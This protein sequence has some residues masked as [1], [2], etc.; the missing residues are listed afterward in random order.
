[1]DRGINNLLRNGF[2]VLLLLLVLELA[3]LKY[4]R[5]AAVPSQPILL[6]NFQFPALILNPLS[7]PDPS[8]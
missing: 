8:A 1:L 7:W 3:R 6:L 2:F 5:R 4:A